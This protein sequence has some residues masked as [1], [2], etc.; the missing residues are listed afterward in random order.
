MITIVLQLM[1]TIANCI[2]AS[3][4]DEDDSNDDTT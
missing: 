2:N 4:D 3:V 1:I